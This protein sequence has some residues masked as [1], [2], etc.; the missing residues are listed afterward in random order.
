MASSKLNELAARKQ[1]L[2]V[3]ADL[4]RQLLVLESARATAGG[5]GAAAFVDR[6]RWWLL[7]GA[8]LAGVVAARRGRALVE[9]LPSLL[10][11]ARAF[12]P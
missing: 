9:W 1:L 5:F 2:I 4:H 8:I 3:Q 12:I 7:G 11:V 10:A 6:N